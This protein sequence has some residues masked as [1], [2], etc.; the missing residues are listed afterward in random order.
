MTRLR[1]AC[2]SGLATSSPASNLGTSRP[3]LSLPS[4]C[5]S[6]HHSPVSRVFCSAWKSKHSAVLKGLGLG[7]AGAV[8]YVLRT[9]MG[10]E[11]ELIG[12]HSS[13]ARSCSEALQRRIAEYVAEGYDPALIADL[14][15]LNSSE[16]VRVWQPVPS[17]R[18]AE[19]RR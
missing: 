10:D 12:H 9:M 8:D 13:A 4:L 5:S 14:R 18:G 16:L 6:S 7:S 15:C 11:S 3:R 19:Q 1:L 17:S 2:S